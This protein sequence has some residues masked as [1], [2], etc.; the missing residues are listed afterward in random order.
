M[1]DGQIQP[2]LKRYFEGILRDQEPDAFD[3]EEFLNDDDDAG[4]VCQ[5]PI[6]KNR[7]FA[8][9]LSDYNSTAAYE[10]NSKKAQRNIVCNIRAYDYRV[11]INATVFDSYIQN[12][13]YDWTKSDY[14]SDYKA[15][16]QLD[17]IVNKDGGIFITDKLQDKKNP[18]REGRG[19]MIFSDGSLYEGD[20]QKD[21]QHGFGRHIHLDGDVHEGQWKENMANG[22]GHYQHVDGSIY[23]GEWKND[24]QHG[25]GV[26]KWP[27]GALFNGEYN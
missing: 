3:S 18:Q 23:D 5:R 15:L 10:S 26:E 21:K 24:L 12:G 1:P 19:L 20:W 22:L 25:K 13:L 11:H 9:N 17:Q 7:D 4:T 6:K 14:P 27:D 2:K 8:E 16:E